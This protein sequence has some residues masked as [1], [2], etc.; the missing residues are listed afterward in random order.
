MKLIF[1]LL[2][3]YQRNGS[4]Q[5]ENILNIE[6]DGD[7]ASAIY[8]S[9]TAIAIKN[10][11]LSDLRKFHLLKNL[12]KLNAT[13]GNMTALE[14]NEFSSLTSLEVLNLKMNEIA[15]IPIKLFS[16]LTNLR[17]LYL[18]ENHVSTIAKQTFEQNVN[19]AIISLSAND[20]EKLHFKTFSFLTSLRELDLSSNR[21]TS[22]QAKLFE[23]NEKLERLDLFNNNLQYI[24]SKILQPLIALA[25]AD[26]ERNPCVSDWI[27]PS[28]IQK[29]N[30]TIIEN[31]A[32]DKE[33]ELQWLRE[34]IEDL[35]AENSALRGGAAMKTVKIG[36]DD[37][38]AENDR[39][40][41]LINCLEEKF[42]LANK[43]N[44][45]H[46]IAECNAKNET[47]VKS[48]DL[49]MKNLEI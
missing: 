27:N 2:L 17:E 22:L 14:G 4:A 25:K 19:L 7:N 38:M 48:E 21:L 46:I 32:A 41:H 15:E 47:L 6:S 36:D 35:K 1:A 45:T 8:E 42:E 29:L 5:S 12:R 49:V 3:I 37:C 9:T 31:C 26:F 18:D 30:E 10:C 43:N 40:N 11:T 24:E 34:E 13:R 23:R 33:T 28:D 16:F 20:I 44:T 39:L